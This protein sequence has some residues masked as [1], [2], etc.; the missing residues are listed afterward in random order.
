MISMSKF[1]LGLIF[2]QNS[3]N[4]E[5][6][7]IAHSVFSNLFEMSC[8]GALIDPEGLEQLPLPLPELLA[9]VDRLVDRDFLSLEFLRPLAMNLNRSD[10]YRNPSRVLGDSIAAANSEIDL[11]SFSQFLGIEPHEKAHEYVTSLLSNNPPSETTRLLKVLPYAL[12]S[13]PTDATLPIHLERARDFLG[14]DIEYVRRTCEARGML[15]DTL[16]VEHFFMIVN[17]AQRWG[18]DSDDFT[19]ALSTVMFAQS[20]SDAPKWVA[21]QD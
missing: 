13:Q 19:R 5:K 10:L 7:R 9:M 1:V 4:H 6:L 3:P 14:R 21:G 16:T 11:S 20:L 12:K 15:K 2:E 8:I 18:V 17:T